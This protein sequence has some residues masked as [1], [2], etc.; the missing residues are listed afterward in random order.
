MQ[1]DKN[2][3]HILFDFD[4]TIANTLPLGF[5]LYNEIADQYNFI[6]ADDSELPQL[7]NMSI[8]EILHLKNIPLYMV[9]I[10]LFNV[11]KKMKQR[12]AEVKPFE[13]IKDFLNN[14]KK[15]G[16]HLSII[17]S[18]SKE[19]M[20]KFFEMND[21]KVFNY[22]YSSTSLF[23]KD[24]LIK[25]YLKAVKTTPDKVIYIGDE[26]RD[27]E[28]ARTSNIKVISVTWGYNDQAILIKNKPDFLA[29]NIRELQNILIPQI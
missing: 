15:A 29:N 25:H 3:D 20:E 11:K 16:Y 14:L 6:S 7:M 27:I 17:S 28:A 1:I 8:T 13:G 18:N 21:I 22:I 26:I 5:E 23:G 2:V 10:A 19:N 9:P 4:G 12:L 24:K